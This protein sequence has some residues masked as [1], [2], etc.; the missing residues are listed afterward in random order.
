[1]TTSSLFVTNQTL[2]IEV[3]NRIFA[4]GR[5]TRADEESLMRAMTSEHP[6][7]GDELSQVRRVLERLQMGLLKVVD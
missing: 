7:S 5:I 3:I 1:M 4:S 6:L 2:L